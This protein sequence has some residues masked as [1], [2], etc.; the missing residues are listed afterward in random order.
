[1]TRV[2]QLFVSLLASKVIDQLVG[3]YIDFFIFSFSFFPWNPL[4]VQTLENPDTDTYRFERERIENRTEN[5]IRTGSASSFSFFYFS[6][7]S[8]FLVERVSEAFHEACSNEGT[9]RSNRTSRLDSR[10]A[11]LGFLLLLMLLYRVSGSFSLP[12]RSHR[13]DLHSGPKR[14][15]TP[16]LFLIVADTCDRSRL[17]LPFARSTYANDY[18]R[19]DAT[20][21]DATPPFLHIFSRF[22]LRL[23]YAWFIRYSRNF[24]VHRASYVCLLCFSIVEISNNHWIAKVSV[25]SIEEFPCSND[26]RSLL[27]PILKV[28]S[29]LQTTHIHIYIYISILHWYTYRISNWINILLR[30]YIILLLSN[31]KF[32]AST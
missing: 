4:N 22:R 16:F 26:R 19:R 15:Q 9:C 27:I 21:R 13:I 1:M 8:S 11:A 5:A 20:R 10:L 2:L 17:G 7:K 30:I 23:W 29:Y 25:F 6:E 18:P 31:S 12:F 28:I 3:S 14:F 32:N 24:I